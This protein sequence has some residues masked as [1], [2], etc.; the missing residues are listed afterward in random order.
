MAVIESQLDTQ[1]EAFKHNL[2][3]MTAAV[4]EFRGIER[5]VI[6]AAQAKAPRY[7]KKGLIPPRER[8]SLLLDAG[9]PFLELSSLCGYMQDEDTDGSAAGGSYIAGIGYIAGVRC[10]VAVDDYLTKGGSIAPMGGKKRNRMMDIAMEN[11][12]PMVNLSQSGGGNLK[13]IGDTFG[14]SGEMFARQCRLSAAG[15]PQITVVHGSATAG[16]AY[17]PTLSDYLILVRKQSTMYLAGPPLLKAATGEIATDEELGGAEMHSEIAGTNDYLAE[18]DA[19]GIRIARD[20]TQKLGWNKNQPLHAEVSYQEPLYAANELRGIVPEDAKT[21]FDMR[22]VI[23]RIADGSDFLEFKGDFDNG[24]LCGHIEIEGEPCGV[25]GNNSPI[26]AKGAAKAAQ[27]IQLC[28]QSGTPLLFLTNTT[29]FLVGTEPEQAGI[30]K[31]GSKFIQAVTNCTVPKITI[32]VGGSYGAGN[33]A[34]AGRGMKPRFLFAWPRS[35]VS[36]MGPAQAGSVLRQVAE[37][38]MARSGAQMTDEMR[39]MIDAMEK[40]T[41]DTMEAKSNALA[42]T[43][44]VWDDGIIDPADTR[45]VVAFALSVCR[46]ADERHVNTNTFGIGRL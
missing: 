46:E 33:Y 21:P 39:G 32:I 34:M 17:Q 7:I 1:S 8:L 43:A 44:R 14:E 10:L 16:G 11:K 27:F 5:R 4:D 18:N 22:E 29:G 23:A 28:E 15:I 20:V 37:A 26:T 13:L 19:D 3:V 42:N 2:K 40:D 30:I 38:K 24:T 9:A 36:V 12:L 25:I 41:V 45:S 35:V 31:H 6:E